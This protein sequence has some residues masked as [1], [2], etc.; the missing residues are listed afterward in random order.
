MP[1]MIFST[2]PLHPDVTAELQTL[3]NLVIASEP[4]PSAILG[5]SAGAS[6]IVVRA[7]I[8][9]EIFGREK[10]LK[11]VVRHGAGLDM[12]PLDAATDA[13]VLVANVPGVN[14]VTV[15]EHCIWSSLALLRRYPAVSAD[16]RSAGWAV[17]RAHSD[18]GRELSQRTI[19][20]VGMGNVGNALFRIAHGGFG[21]KVLAVTSRPEAL[22]A[23]AEAADLKHVLSHS[24]VVVLACPLNDKTRGIIGA[25][26]LALMQPGAILVNV[27]RGPVIDEKALIEALRSGPIGGAVLDVFDRQPLPDDHPFLS[28]R[29]VIL[30]PHMAGITEESMLRMGQGV[31]METRRILAGNKPVNLCNPAVW[32]NYVS[33]FG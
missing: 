32:D 9:S 8:P 11:A 2:H 17:A 6:I 26:E 29:N 3:G 5:E 20:I 24:D 12:I 16:L 18:H 13:G 7:P 21:M 19:G 4:S 22:P 23:G 31:V 27:A 30:T 28:M 25:D 15:A 33:R 1:D 14:A 10:A